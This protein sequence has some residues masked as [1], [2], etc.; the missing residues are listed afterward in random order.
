[1]ALSKKQHKELL[2]QTLQANVTFKSSG[3]IMPFRIVIDGFFY[4]VYIKNLSSAHFETKNKVSD[5]WRAQLPSD[6][7]F[8]EMKESPI[9]FIFLGYDEKND[10]YATWNP[11]KVKQRLNEAKYVSFYSR[12]S[13]QKEAH[14]EDKFVRLKLNNDGEVL[15][16]PR[17]KLSTYLVN[18]E[19]YFSDMSDYVA[20]GS[21][22]R[23][24]AN[25][26][27]RE[28][29]NTKNIDL[30]AKFLK[31]NDYND[32]TFYCRCLK[33]L[34]N[35]GKFS[36]HRKDFLAC[37]TIYQYDSAIERFMQNEDIKELDINFG[38]CINKI[39]FTYVDF[40]KSKFQKADDANDI[41]CDTTNNNID[42]DT[43]YYKNGKI[44]KVTNPDL[45]HKIEPHLN[46]EYKAIMVAVN[47]LKEY[48][49]QK[50]ELKMEIK[51]W[52]KLANQIDWAT[53]YDEPVV[54]QKDVT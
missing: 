40:L 50:F 4:N 22:R 18:M 12:W 14:D 25:E 17:T 35:K 48:Y 8:V 44:T 53:C 46:T 29:N 52:I 27:Y 51:D 2:E 49:S 19:T 36:Q 42:K 20:I 32:I 7:Q 34:I 43:L 45:L 26:A 10:V 33:S 16:F 5:V 28:L 30:Y 15:I 1:M 23:T 39:L 6:D 37:D 54:T 24:E 13:G 9:P 41:N 31:E 47:L 38:R 21:K 3:G 11:H